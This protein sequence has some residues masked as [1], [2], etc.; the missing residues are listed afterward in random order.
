MKISDVIKKER[1][2]CK[3]C[4]L[5]HISQAVILT[6]EMQQGYPEHSSLAKQHIKEANSELG[7]DTNLNLYLKLIYDCVDSNVSIAHERLLKFLNNQTNDIDKWL[8]VGHLA[9][10]SE[11]SIKDYP[12]LANKIRE[13]RL[14]VMADEEVDLKELMKEILNEQIHVSTTPGL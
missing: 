10:A 6:S 3:D 8:A 1:T 11:E 12:E 2:S 9:E 14:K 4:M 5:K 13:Y 7:D